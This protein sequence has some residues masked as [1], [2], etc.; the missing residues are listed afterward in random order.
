[1]GFGLAVS[2]ACLDHAHFE[3]RNAVEALRDGSERRLS[4]LLAV[5]EILARALVDHHDRDRGQEVAIL[6]RD[7][8]IGE[9]E[10]EQSKRDGAG[11][12]AAAAPEH[13]Q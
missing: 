10:H 13:D 4:L 7:R 8:G 5:T 11:E 2:L 6:A 12:R 3:A 1:M 9:R